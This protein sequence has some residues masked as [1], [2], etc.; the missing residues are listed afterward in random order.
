MKEILLLTRSYTT[1]NELENMRHK[2]MS[3]F[4][5]LSLFILTKIKPKRRSSVFNL[6]NAK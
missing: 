5:N 6:Y 1:P 4:I 3:L 2:P